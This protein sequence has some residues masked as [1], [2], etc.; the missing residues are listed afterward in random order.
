[1]EVRICKQ[2]LQ[3]A[4]SPSLLITEDTVINHLIQ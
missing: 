1:V 3:T 2:E 4:I